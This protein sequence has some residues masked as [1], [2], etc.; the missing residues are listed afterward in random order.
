MLRKLK[1][2]L[3]GLSE[4]VWENLDCLLKIQVHSFSH[5]NNIERMT[6]KSSDKMVPV[7]FFAVI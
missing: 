5:D 3:D 1:F 4:V 2:T 6:P 7:S